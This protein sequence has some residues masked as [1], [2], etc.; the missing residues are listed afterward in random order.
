MKC[1]RCGYDAPEAARF[2]PSCGAALPTSVAAAPGVPIVPGAAAADSG[3]PRSD[4]DAASGGRAAPGAAD[5]A[6]AG[7]LR[8]A[9][10]PPAT[11]RYRRRERPPM[12]PLDRF[13]E[14]DRPPPP[15][16]RPPINWMR[17]A[18][19]VLATILILAILLLA[20]IYFQS[21]ANQLW[22]QTRCLDLRQRC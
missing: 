2:C 1:D 16:P 8:A 13:Q 19:G 12:V 4:R 11:S 5:V 20:L 17:V 15:P 9:G 22:Q 18:I 7:M 14:L 3:A 10:P 6:P 21:Q